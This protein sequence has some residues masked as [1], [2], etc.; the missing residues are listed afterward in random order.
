MSKGNGVLVDLTRCIGCGSCTVACKMWNKLEFQEDHPATG[1]HTKLKDH[2]WTVLETR[3]TE[4]E[5]G[6]PI[7]RYVK[8]QCMHCLDPACASVCF[9]RAIERRE[10]GAV[11]YYPDL[12]VGCRY[13]MVACPFDVA[14]YE[15]E[16]PFPA[17][18]KCQFCS[19]R[20]ENH[21]V[22]ACISVCPTHVMEFGR[23]DK[24]LEKAQARI[25]AEPNKY[26]PHIYGA[27]EVG[28]T[29]WMYISDVPFDKL[30]FNTELGTT[31]ATKYSNSWMKKV[32]Y[33][34][35]GW[36]ALATAIS[37]YTKRRAENEKKKREEKRVAKS[38]EKA[39]ERNDQ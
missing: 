33:I 1:E 23:R 24:L 28:G 7:W 15:W 9:S 5:D 19:S 36:A 30:G 37:V 8:R 3:K 2:N 25:A 29:S 11:V 32:P 16:S 38:E 6:S 20:L 13:C 26:V 21:E 4:M 35:I 17:V 27:E 18:M 34:A 39:G 22:P 12:C 31:T 10:D 14:K